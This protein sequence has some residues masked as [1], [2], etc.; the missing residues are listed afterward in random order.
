QPQITVRRGGTLHVGSDRD[1]VPLQPELR[2]APTQA[3]LKSGPAQQD[4]QRLFVDAQRG[5]LHRQAHARSA[6]RVGKGEAA[7]R[8]DLNRAAVAHGAGSVRTRRE[9]S[10]IS[11][12]TP[13]A[14][15]STVVAPSSPRFAR[16]RL[17]SVTV[18]RGGVSRGWL[19][20]RI[21]LSAASVSERSSRV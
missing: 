7:Q 1:A 14:Q 2:F 12:R 9:P 19:R 4:L 18:T 5:A 20:A 11:I 16:V 17:P 6:L 3:D 8:A 13:G 15:I 10:P 21:V